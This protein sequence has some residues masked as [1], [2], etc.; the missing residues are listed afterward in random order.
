MDSQWNAF[1]CPLGQS[2]HKGSSRVV[3]R[4]VGTPVLF[5]VPTPVLPSLT[6]P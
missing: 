3:L 6:K 5:L 1:G 2:D 4:T